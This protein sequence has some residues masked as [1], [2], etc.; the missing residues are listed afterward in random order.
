MPAIA[1]KSF[2]PTANQ[3]KVQP[4]PQPQ[5]WLYTHTPQHASARGGHRPPAPCKP[6]CCTPTVR[7]VAHWLL[8]HGVTSH[9]VMLHCPILE[10]TQTF[11]AL[12]ASAYGNASEQAPDCAAN[13]DA[14]RGLLAA[15]QLCIDREGA[16]G[17]G[18]DHGGQGQDQPV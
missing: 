2:T 14:D 10:L 16:A 3:P 9:N 18:L 5:P 13:C 7:H 12:C 4:R 1:P 17:W 8:H 11:V 15:V 6:Y